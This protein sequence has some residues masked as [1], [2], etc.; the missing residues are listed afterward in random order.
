MTVTCPNYRLDPS[1][2]LVASAG[3]TGGVDCTAHAA[4]N[5]IDHATCG[6]KDPGGRTIRLL[7]NEPTPDPR[8]P[9]LNLGQVQSVAL[10]H[11]GVY[12]E[13]HTGRNAVSWAT[14]EA[15]RKAGQGTEI[16]LQ[17]DVIADSKYDAFYSRFR[18]GHAMSETFYAT[19]DPG[20]HGRPG[21][22]KYNGTL[23]TRELIKTA[24]GRLIIGTNADGSLRRVGYGKVWCA[25]TRDV[26]P[27]YRVAIRPVNGFFRYFVEDGVIT[28]RTDRIEGR[29]FSA[30]CTVPLSRLW[31]RSEN[32]PGKRYTLVRVTDRRSAYFDW[33]VSAVFA[34]EI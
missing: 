18:G 4:S 9:G 5:C 1:Y 26:V 2:Q 20:A 3:S 14:Y 33:Y 13:V 10:R 21:A 29:S 27:D 32:G 24:A 19:M 30:A 17:Y 23:Y 31:P 22:W 6:A 15:R 7:S 11:F 8:S 34:K 16:Q 12:L 25:F 28:G